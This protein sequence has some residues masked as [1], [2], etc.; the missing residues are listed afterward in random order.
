MRL[1]AQARKLMEDRL[2][3]TPG[4]AEGGQF[5]IAVTGKGIGG[6]AEGLKN[7]QGTK[8]DRADGRLCHL[9]CA[10]R[11]FLVVLP[12]RHQRRD[13]IDQVGKPF[14]RRRKSR[15]RQRQRCQRLRE[16]AGEI[17]EHAGILGTLAGKEHGQCSRAA[18]AAK[19]APSGVFQL[20]AAFCEHGHGIGDKSRQVGTVALDH[21]C[22]PAGE[23]NGRRRSGCARFSPQFVPGNVGGESA[24][25]G[26]PAPPQH[27]PEKAS[28][29]DV[30]VPVN[31]L[32]LPADTPQ[33]P[34]GNWNRRSRRR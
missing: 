31:R 26:L 15:H 23:R 10:Q 34:H 19:K 33:E 4:R 16:T 29:L 30:T 24:Q 18:S 28:N 21:Q 13:R 25:G 6:K 7:P 9:G 17:A 2:V 12:L 5:A 8:T 3:E 20:A 11:R 22:E 32:P 14:H 1:P 27:V